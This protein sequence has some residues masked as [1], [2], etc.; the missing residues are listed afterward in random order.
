M[1]TVLHLERK[2]T[3]KT[4]TFI[5]NQINTIKN[6]N[7]IVATIYDTKFLPCEKRL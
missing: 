2:F 1:Q 3:S 5:V 7:V 4:E 6:F